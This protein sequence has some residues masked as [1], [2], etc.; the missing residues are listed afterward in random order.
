MIS[1]KSQIFWDCTPEGHS[2]YDQCILLSLLGRFLISH[3]VPGN[4]KPKRKPYA[5]TIVIESHT[6]VNLNE[7]YSYETILS[8]GQW[9][10]K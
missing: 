7:R 4:A 10:I 6:K 5:M 3:T 9:L 8:N 2:Q 1:K